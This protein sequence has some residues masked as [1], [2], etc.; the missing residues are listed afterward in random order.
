MYVLCVLQAVSCSLR[1]YTGSDSRQHAIPA[2]LIASLSFILYKVIT[3]SHGVEVKALVL[4]ARDLEFGS[5]Q[6]HKICHPGWITK[7]TPPREENE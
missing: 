6:W 1:R 4:H 7:L 5:W 3:S 2:G